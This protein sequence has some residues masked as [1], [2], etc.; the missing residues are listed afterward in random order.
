MHDSNEY[1]FQYCLEAPPQQYFVFFILVFL[2]THSIGIARGDREL[3]NI[4]LK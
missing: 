2:A 4:S 3:P 1:S